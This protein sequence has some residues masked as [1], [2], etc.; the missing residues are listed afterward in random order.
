MYTGFNSSTS[1]EM[2]S[3]ISAAVYS[4]HKVGRS[5]PICR[6]FFRECRGSQQP[7]VRRGNVYQFVVVV[8]VVEEALELDTLFILSP[9]FSHICTYD[10][11]SHADLEHIREARG[12]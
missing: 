2:S 11:H 3:Y 12:G 10:T 6:Q 5:S 8:V 7:P 4:S 9:S 1:S